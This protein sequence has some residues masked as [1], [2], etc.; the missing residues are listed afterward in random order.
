MADII[1]EY[2][3]EITEASDDDSTYSIDN[4]SYFSHTSDW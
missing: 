3:D 2:D 4:P 1:F